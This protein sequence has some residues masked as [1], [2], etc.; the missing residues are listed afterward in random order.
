MWCSA[1]C[2]AEY[3]ASTWRFRCRCAFKGDSIIYGVHELRWPGSERVIVIR[4]VTTV[5]SAGA[6]TVAKLSI[7]PMRTVTH[8]RSPAGIRERRRS[9]VGCPVVQQALRINTFVWFSDLP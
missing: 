2:S 9:A 5:R 6:R 8:G 3:P 7:S 4:V 1:T